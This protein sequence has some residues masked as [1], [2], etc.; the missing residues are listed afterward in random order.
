[1]FCEIDTEDE[2]CRFVPIPCEKDVWNIPEDT[3]IDATELDMSRFRDNIEDFQEEMNLES[4][5]HKFVSEN[6]FPSDITDMIYRLSIVEQLTEYN[7]N[8][9]KELEELIK[10]NQA[11]Q[12]ELT[13]KENQLKKTGTKY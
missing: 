5:W 3:D 2:T 4:A 12:Q 1:M 13:E 9:M 7:D 6:E 10:K 8:L 11:K